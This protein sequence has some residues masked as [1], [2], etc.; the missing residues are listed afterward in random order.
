[1][2]NIIVALETNQ[3]FN[4]YLLFCDKKKSLIEN[5]ELPNG[6]GRNI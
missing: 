2:V 3:Q 6:F 5:E 1:M 4:N